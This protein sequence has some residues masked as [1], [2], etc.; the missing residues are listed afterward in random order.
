MK[1]DNSDHFQ[2]IPTNSDQADL[3]GFNWK[4]PPGEPGQEHQVNAR[5]RIQRNMQSFLP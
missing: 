3:V 4:P 5:S 2:P 1:F